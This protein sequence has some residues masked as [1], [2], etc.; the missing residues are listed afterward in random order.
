MEDNDV[1]FL[2]LE[3]PLSMTSNIVLASDEETENFITRETMARVYGYGNTA[4]KNGSSQAP[5]TTTMTLSFKSKTV[6]NSAYLISSTSSACPGDSGGPV[7]VSTPTKLY[8]I[9]IVSGGAKC[10]SWTRVCSKNRWLLL[11]FNYISHQVCKSGI[12]SCD[13][14]RK[15][16]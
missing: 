7:V 2:V 16:C 12:C 10:G 8:L 3:N 6:M 4:F 14:S 9:G 11:H 1:A 15:S 5:M 13:G